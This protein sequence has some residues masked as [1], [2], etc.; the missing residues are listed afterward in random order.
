MGFLALIVLMLILLPL[1]F[2]LRIN[3]FCLKLLNGNK[4]W[5]HHCND[6]CTWISILLT[7]MYIVSSYGPVLYFM[8]FSST[9][10]I[11]GCYASSLGSI[12]PRA[13]C[14]KGARSCF[15]SFL[16]PR[17]LNHPCWWRPLVVFYIRPLPSSLVWEE[18]YYS[19]GRLCAAPPH[20]N[21]NS[22]SLPLADADVPMDVTSDFDSG[23]PWH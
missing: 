18:C 15:L 21:R 11:R 20:L 1:I 8:L 7:N 12:F 23:R 3:V 13:C 5:I 16:T 17:C 4:D 10:P 6:N 22:F 19:S 2:S 14:R 9:F